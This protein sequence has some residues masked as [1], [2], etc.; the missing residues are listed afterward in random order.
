MLME[1]FGKEPGRQVEVFVVLRG[2]P[3]GVLLR[4]I[5]RAAVGRQVRSDCEFTSAQHQKSEAPV[6]SGVRDW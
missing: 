2:Q 1:V 5:G 6:D 3:P 4:R